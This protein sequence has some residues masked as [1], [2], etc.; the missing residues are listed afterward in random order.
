MIILRFYIWVISFMKIGGK[1]YLWENKFFFG[2]VEFDFLMGYIVKNNQKR[3]GVRN[4][5]LRIG[6]GDEELF[7]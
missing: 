3:I 5:Q 4:I 2:Y 6:D 7:L 1:Q